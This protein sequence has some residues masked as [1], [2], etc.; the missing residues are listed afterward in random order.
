MLHIEHLLVCGLVVT[1]TCEQVVT[2][3][4][5]VARVRRWT[6]KL[7]IDRSEDALLGK[8]TA[9][10]RGDLRQI[11]RTSRDIRLHGT[12]SVTVEPVTS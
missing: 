2:P 10:T 11:G 6:V 1:F 12:S 7:P 8:Y 5:H 3:D 4:G 9:V